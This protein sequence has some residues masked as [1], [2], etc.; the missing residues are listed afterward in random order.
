[1]SSLPERPNLDH[2]RKQ[3]KELLLQFHAH[4]PAA[5]ASFRRHL[6]AAKDKSDAE[7][8]TMLLRLRD[9]QSC[10][11][12]QYSFQSWH[13]LKQF[14]ELKN[15]SASGGPQAVD[16][17]RPSNTPTLTPAQAERARRRY[18]QARPRTAV[19]LDPESFDKYVGYYQLFH[20]PTTF[21]HIFRDGERFLEQ[22]N[23][24]KRA[25]VPPV[26]F[27]PES[28]TKFFATIVVSQ[29]SF[30]SD[31]QGQVTGLVFHQHGFLWPAKKVDESVVE[32]YEAWLEQRIES[33]AP[34]PGTEAFLRRYIAAWEKG[35]PNYHELQPGLAKL[36][37]R[38]HPIMENRTQRV[39]AFK[40]LS[41]KGVDRRGWDVY[42]VTFV[43]GE[44]EYRV[45]P[46]AA[47][48][49]VSG[50]AGREVP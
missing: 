2:L 22:L 20:K 25:G 29:I 14:V 4:D 27:Y 34:S 13:E 36:A 9:A 12:R 38:Q 7:L 45:A 24:E 47:D 44:V 30:V 40:D 26:E 6:P 21:T 50:I 17:S 49:K 18:E 37:Q 23:T 32:S 1:M 16:G 19:P 11:A 31:A 28:D 41:F 42:Q 33:N 39:G 3:A 8:S 35:Q 43:R 46:L 15:S 5:L 48:G 10:I